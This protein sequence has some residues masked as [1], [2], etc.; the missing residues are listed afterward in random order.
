MNRLM[1]EG[2][3]LIKGFVGVQSLNRFG[4]G[5]AGLNKGISRSEWPV[6]RL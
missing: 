4:W 1:G 6:L 5:Q 2:I 3:G